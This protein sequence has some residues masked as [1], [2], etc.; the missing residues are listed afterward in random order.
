MVHGS[1]VSIE[2]SVFEYNVSRSG[3][4]IY[5]ISYYAYPD[6]SRSIFR[7]NYSSGNG[8]LRGGV[9]KECLIYGNQDVSICG[10]GYTASFQNSTII[11]NSSPANYGALYGCRSVLNSIVVYNYP[12]DVDTC[13]LTNS[14]YARINAGTQ[15]NSTNL[16]PL[17]VDHDYYSA[18]VI[19]NG[20]Q[21]G[22][23]FVLG[24]LGLD[25]LKL[26]ADSPA[27]NAGTK[28]TSLSA[29][30]YAG[31]DR[32][33]ESIVDIGAYEYYATVAGPNP[34][35]LR[36]FHQLITRGRP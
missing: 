26:Q 31:L 6:V 18:L 8:P 15:V 5:G 22:T 33:N 36:T 27:R 29:T 20:S 9:Y 34:A 23:N 7:Y 16:P 11:G 3:A 13:F 14:I 2:D 35:L 1:F 25:G 24:P 30:D 19:T 32:I 28:A 17:L 10:A 12:R 21:L 4:A